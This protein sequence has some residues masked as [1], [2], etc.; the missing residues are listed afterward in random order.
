VYPRACKFGK[1]V[2]FITLDIFQKYPK[3]KSNTIASY[4]KMVSMT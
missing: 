1:N 3:P 2:I 4:L